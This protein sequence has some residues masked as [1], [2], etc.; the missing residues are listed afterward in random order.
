MTFRKSTLIIT[1]AL[2]GFG[3]IF[4]GAN[5]GQPSDFLAPA[6]I[7]PESRDFSTLVLRDSWDMSQ[8]SDIS[9]YLN[10]SGQRSIVDNVKVADGV[11]T[12]TSVGDHN[13]A[14]NGYFFPLFP[15]YETAM[16]IGKV[17]HRYPVDSSV[18]KCLYISMK[19]DSPAANNFGPDQYRIFWFADE[20]MNTGGAPYGF[21]HGIP[22][23]P[24]SGRDK[25][26]PTWKLFR[27]DLSNPPTGIGGQ[28]WRSQPYWQG[29]RI[30]P[31]INGGVNFAVDWVRLTDCQANT[32]TVT[33]RPDKSLTTL[34][35]QPEGKQNYIQIATGVSGGSGSYRLD[36]QGLAAGKYT[37]G[38]S[39]S[40]TSCCNVQSTEPLVINQTPVAV[41]NRPSP[42][43]GKD[44]AREVGNPWDF[45]DSTDVISVQDANSVFSNGILD[46]VTPP[47]TGD[48]MIFLNSPRALTNS[49]TYRYLNFR[50][51]T[52]GPWQNAPEGMIVRWIWVTPG[53][54]GGGECFLVSQDIPL[55]VGWHTYTID[56]HDSYNGSPEQAAGRCDG[57][58]HWNDNSQINRFRFDPNENI[59]NIPLHQQL[60]WIR[61]TKVDRVTQGNPFPVQI[62]LN[63]PSKGLSRID[64]YY[65]NN[66]SQPTQHKADGKILS[67]QSQG[68]NPEA[69]VLQPAETAGLGRN[70]VILPLVMANFVEIDFPP[71]TDGVNFSW[72]T[73]NVSPGEYYLCTVVGDAYNQATY[74]S[75][76]PIQ[77]V[78]P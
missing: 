72:S 51:Y 3:V 11:F 43:S 39:S 7:V 67:G 49:D 74:C 33:W 66:L 37:V 5:A 36:V 15:G 68:A 73:S 13:Q 64:F 77:V 23:Y 22:L 70:R 75:E 60:D 78:V 14:S 30:D 34:W 6:A 28:A 20:R 48:P 18:Y 50:M 55:D 71:L 47:S 12:G 62:S 69:A 61:L 44:Y 32:Q 38:L 40:N 56:L 25:P 76:A 16:L 4:S 58:R 65:T 63:K 53:S 1:L 54:G 17:G 2:L 21:T 41:F 52:E 19:V 42:T 45:S 24:E 27:I 10:E 31:T 29:L 35:L 57:L 59:R 46:L 8:F 26:V 9:Q